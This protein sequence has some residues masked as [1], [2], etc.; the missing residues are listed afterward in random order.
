MNKLIKTQSD[1]EIKVFLTTLIA[2]IH[3]TAG[4]KATN[5]LFQVETLANDL[6]T[7][8]PGFTQD[9]I[10]ECFHA[11]VRKEFGEYTGLSVVA[12]YDWLKKYQYSPIRHKPELKALPQKTELTESEKEKI[13]ID[14]S[15]R[16]FE[17]YKKT[18]DCQDIGNVTYTYLDSLGLIQFDE[19]RKRQIYDQTKSRLILERS[20]QKQ[21]DFF[22]RK[23][24][25]VEIERI[26]KG[27]DEI[28]VIESKK[29]ALKIYFKELIEFGNELKDV[30]ETVEH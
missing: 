5:V 8:F 14:G 26:N 29:E 17:E 9:E 7:H 10:R 16:K 27:E 23:E 11:G 4:F 30:L 19:K 3:A 20:Q 6:K 21:R 13:I 12:Y 28:I 24:L 25:A 15:L 18:G 22:K 1:K 2:E